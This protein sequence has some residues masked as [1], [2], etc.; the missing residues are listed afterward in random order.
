MAFNAWTLYTLALASCRTS[1]PIC[2]V[3]I[4]C[5][6]IALNV[7]HNLQSLHHVQHDNSLCLILIAWLWIMTF[8]QMWLAR[9]LPGLLV[10]EKNVWFIPYWWYHIQTTRTTPV[11]TRTSYPSRF[12]TSV[13]PAYVMRSRYM[14]RYETLQKQFRLQDMWMLYG[15]TD[16]HFV[17]HIHNMVSILYRKLVL[18][19]SGCDSTSKVGPKHVSLK[20]ASLKPHLLIIE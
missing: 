14:Y 16:T 19:L 15:V 1:M 9:V 12:D 5:N 7:S 2:K 17:V 20:Q 3:Y 8:W 18:V 6:P 13:C 11:N 10:F 4:M